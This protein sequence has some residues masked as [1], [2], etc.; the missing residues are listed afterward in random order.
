MIRIDLHDYYP[1]EPIGSILEVPIEIAEAL[2][3]F[4]RHEVALQVKEYRYR[5]YYTLDALDGI[6]EK[7]LTQL[8]NP[9]EILED[10]FT[11]EQL[12]KALSMLPEKQSGRVYKYFVL[13]MSYS[14]IARADAV[15]E[16]SVRRGITRSLLVMREFL[17]N[18][19]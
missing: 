9:H 2:E 17:K 8:K 3:S 5:A 7:A 15:N 18:I 12:D 13:N 10:E 6:E 16:S 11:E 19:L 1:H 4:E 14:E